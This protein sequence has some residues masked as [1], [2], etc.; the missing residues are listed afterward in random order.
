MARLAQG[1]KTVA[2]LIAALTLAAPALNAS[3]GADMP[4]P[5]HG[6]GDRCVE[7]TAFMRR[8]HMELLKHHR[9]E[10]LRQGIRTTKYSLKGCV[11][12]HASDKTGSVAASKEDFCV[13][14]HEYAGT[15]LD[16]WDCHATKPGRKQTAVGDRK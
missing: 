4:K 12:C 15:D 6:K 16:C 13:S 8:N 3:A 7:D 10:T 1:L 5:M 11:E 2:L 14:C 9:N